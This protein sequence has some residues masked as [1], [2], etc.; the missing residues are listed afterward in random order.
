ML[1][2]VE[3]EHEKLWSRLGNGGSSE[4]G[5]CSVYFPT[6]VQISLR[7]TLMELG[8]CADI[9]TLNGLKEESK[10]RYLQTS[11]E[12]KAGYYPRRNFL[13]SIYTYKYRYRHMYCM[14]LYIYYI[15]Q[16]H[17]IALL[18]LI[19]V[20]HIGEMYFNRYI[21]YASIIIINND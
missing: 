21:W 4:G 17:S 19:F 18:H 9:N 13:K 11:V 20:V 16:L 8:N 7:I 3:V 5:C 2:K 12:H 14:L 1:Y 6:G 15:L 10:H